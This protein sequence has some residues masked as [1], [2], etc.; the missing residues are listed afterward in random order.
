[1]KTRTPQVGSALDRE[2]ELGA[3]G[4]ADPVALH[5]LDPLG[6]L[7]VVEGVEQLVGVLR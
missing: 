6:P 5:D 3:L 1:M 7:E 2:V 4:A